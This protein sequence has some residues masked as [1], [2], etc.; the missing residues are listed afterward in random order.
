MLILQPSVYS[1]KETAFPAIMGI[2]YIVALYLK[3]GHYES[4]RIVCK[5][6][7]CQSSFLVFSPKVAYLNG[8]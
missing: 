5:E 7:C 4:S 6:L 1:S 8:D 3:I 2:S